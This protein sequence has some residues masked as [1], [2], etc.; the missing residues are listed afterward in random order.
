M[1]VETPLPERPLRVFLCHSSGDK[2]AVRSLYR[3]LETEG[4]D[5]WLDEEDLI[6]GEEWQKVIPKAVRRSD[7]VLVC[8]SAQ[9]IMKSGYVQKE[10]SYALDVAEEQPEGTIFIIPL[11]LELCE[12]PDRLSRW[13]WVDLYSEDGYEKLTR[14]LRRRLETLKEDS[15]PTPEEQPESKTVPAVIE[16]DDEPQATPDS[17][18]TNSLS[19]EQPQSKP[20]SQSPP[21]PAEPQTTQESEP[22][23]S[24][25]IATGT[26]TTAG[27]KRRWYKIH[28]GIRAVIIVVAAAALITASYQLFYK[29]VPVPPAFFQYTGRVVNADTR[30]PVRNAKVTIEETAN[31]LQTQKT[32]AEGIFRLTLPTSTN[33]AHLWV[34]AEKYHDFNIHMAFPGTDLEE[35]RLVPLDP[36][37]TPSPE[38][39]DSP[40]VSNINKNPTRVVVKSPPQPSRNRNASSDLEQRRRKALDALNS[41]G[42]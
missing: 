33:S 10:I 27:E 28:P 34:Q 13:H 5:P 7:V 31:S 20:V 8:L 12:V 16:S 1:N 11:R 6:P 15:A 41:N 19:E 4:F 9:S 39:T 3:K 37:T 40:A 24:S 32:D 18:P 38:P 25:T 14:A 23:A 26:Q 42:N 17:E 21:A 30:E 2:T 29:Q 36:E 22:V 35:V